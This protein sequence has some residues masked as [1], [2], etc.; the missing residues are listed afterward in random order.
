L[1]QLC[2][3]ASVLGT[4]LLILGFMHAAFILGRAASGSNA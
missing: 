1:Q 4:Y 2:S 3:G